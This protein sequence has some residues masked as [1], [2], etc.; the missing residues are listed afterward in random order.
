MAKACGSVWPEADWEQGA[1]LPGRARDEAE[2]SPLS[3]P[4][5]KLCR[6]NSISPIPAVSWTSPGCQ[7][8]SGA[9]RPHSQLQLHSSPCSTP[10]KAELG[11][12]TLHCLSSLTVIPLL[13]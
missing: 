10:S 1:F 2:Q 6:S 8:S 12:N 4:S 13:H 9:T 5:R 11:A 3:L 7:Q